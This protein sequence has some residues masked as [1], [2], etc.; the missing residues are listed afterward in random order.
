MRRKSERTK[1]KEK[2][3]PEKKVEKTPRRSRRQSRRRKGS[4]SS[5]DR[6]ESGTED[7]ET[8]MKSSQEDTEEEQVA[9][10]EETS[11]VGAV[12][13]ADLANS[14]EVEEV[15]QTASTRTRR[16]AKKHGVEQ[17]TPVEPDVEQQTTPPV[18][19]KADSSHDGEWKEDN[20][21]WEEGDSKP[22]SPDPKTKEKE[23][24]SSVW[25]VKC[26]DTK[27]GEIQKL[28]LCIV[29]PPDPPEP[30]GRKKKRLRRSSSS[31]QKEKSDVEDYDS[32]KGSQGEEEKLSSDEKVSSKNE[33]DV[34]EEEQQIETVKEHQDDSPEDGVVQINI[35]EAE[36]I[37]EE[38]EKEEDNTVEVVKDKEEEDNEKQCQENEEEDGE[39]TQKCDDRHSEEEETNENKEEDNNSETIK[40][41]IK[42][43]PPVLEGESETGCQSDSSPEPDDPNSTKEVP[44]TEEHEPEQEKSD[45]T[46][47]SGQCTDEV[48]ITP[49]DEPELKF[50]VNDDSNENEVKSTSE[51]VAENS[52]DCSMEKESEKETGNS[53]LIEEKIKSPKERLENDEV[54]TSCASNDVKEERRSDSSEDEKESPRNDDSKDSS[55]R[56]RQRHVERAR[57]KEQEEI[58]HERLEPKKEELS[59]IKSR[60]HLERKSRSPQR[61]E[62]VSLR[63]SF[64]G[65][66]CELEQ[67]KGSDYSQHKEKEEFNENVNQENKENDSQKMETGNVNSLSGIPRKR[68]W[69]QSN[70]SRP[71]KR[72][73]LSISTDSLKTLIPGAK[74][75]PI[76]EVQLIQDE[77]IKRE[78][79]IWENEKPVER[80]KIKNEIKEDTVR[81]KPPLHLPDASRISV[82]VTDDHQSKIVTRKI[83]IVSDDARKLQRSPSPPRHK[84]TNVLFITNLV[85]PFTVNQLKELL[86][87]TGKII[88]GGFWIDKIKS[89]CYVEYENES[90]AKETRH[91]L[92][93]V[94]WPVSNPKTLCVDFGKKEDMEMAQAVAESDQIPRKTE[95]LKV[96]RSVDWVVEQ[97]MREKERE[98]EVRDREKEK[99]RE[100]ERERTRVKE[101]P[102]HVPAEPVEHNKKMIVREWDLG[103]IGQSSPPERDNR[104]DEKNREKER[105]I[106]KDKPHRSRSASPHDVSVRKVKKK[107][108]DAPAKLLDDLFRKTKTTPCIYWLPL[109][110]EQIVVK[111]EM[112]RKHMA[113]HERRMAEM[114]KAERERERVRAQQRQQR[115]VSEREK[116]RRRSGSGS[117]K[118]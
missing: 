58:S 93:G 105:K 56:F 42:E 57:S 20:T 81:E 16:S 64:S 4:V 77:D 61:R 27:G 2:P 46:E 111:E 99:E 115:R 72:P 60:R 71:S 63:R 6:D 110:A 95:P 53:C 92:H 13:T 88:E 80:E 87:R 117:L 7:N 49:S 79:D 76:G 33:A 75:V 89:K 25:K 82:A 70:S 34:Q 11:Q 30:A 74:P 94:R 102:H 41:K 112:R 21:F 22:K 109:T 68:R 116:R 14:S 8:S 44:K 29:R 36:V 96:E 35:S 47:L 45:C 65:K 38:C 67:L 37:T 101:R 78:S 90:E 106:R 83:S 24:S 73:V 19:A 32:S 10:L 3:S 108:E 84:A 43:S 40:E 97:Q 118:K 48:Q 39:K 55:P 104:Y 114:R 52:R 5:P 9:S 28:K 1:E 51:I 103:K 98:R 26:S 17:T 113:E 66:S 59:S 18:A 12:I 100:R 107:E 91:A 54:K 69:G 15:S 85:R 50:P 31:Q 62:K 86:A 23:V